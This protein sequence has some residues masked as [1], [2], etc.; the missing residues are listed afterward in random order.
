[1]EKI[2]VKGIVRVYGYY[3]DKKN[4][5]FSWGLVKELTWN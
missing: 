1:M 5:S 3:T 2:L 4:M